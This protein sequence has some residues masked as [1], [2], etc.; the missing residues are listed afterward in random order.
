MDQTPRKK[1]NK[2]SII[3]LIL[4]VILIALGTV[5]VV[6]RLELNRLADPAASAEQTRQSADRLRDKVSKIM[7]VPDETPTIATVQDVDKLR[8]QDFFKDAEN[9]DKVLIFTSAKRAIIYREGQNRIINSG[10]IVLTGNDVES[11]P[12]SQSNQ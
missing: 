2:K 5:L 9:G 11:T 12:E 4:L 6:Q 3:T 1:L 10:P 8:E 7:Q